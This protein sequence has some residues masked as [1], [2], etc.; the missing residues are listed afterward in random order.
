MQTIYIDD[1]GLAKYMAY[2]PATPQEAA[3][4]EVKLILK[5]WKDFLRTYRDPLATY[6]VQWLRTYAPT[7]MARVS[8]VQGDT[9]PVNFMFDGDRV[10]AVI[11]WEWGH[12]GDPM[13]DLGNICV[14]EFWNPSGGLTG[15]F[16][17]YEKESS[18][19]YD[20]QTVLYYRVQQNVRGMI[21]IHA[22]TVQAHYREPVAWFLAY[23]YIGD[24]A[25]CQ[26]LAEAMG[27]AIERPGMPAD[28]DDTDVLAEAGRWALTNDILPHVQGLFPQSRVNDV[29]VLIQCMDRRRRYGAT[30]AGIER[31]ELG[32]LLGRRP[33]TAA[34]GLRKLDAAIRKGTLD[35]EAT[36]RYLTRRAYREEWLH[37]PAVTLYPERNWSPID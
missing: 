36:L 29:N 2:N 21:P 6:G 20:R 11:D 5:Q 33:R 19:P 28:D 34:D 1:L 18:I 12:Y 32:A 27:L 35:D 31:E 9:G 30:I 8:L 3:L 24:R 23:R 17:L 7:E 37:A 4:G 10:S 13:E 25:T 26:A 15:L 22:V 16:R 14:R